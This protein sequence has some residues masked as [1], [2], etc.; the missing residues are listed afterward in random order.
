MVGRPASTSMDQI[1]RD[2]ACLPEDIPILMQKWER[3]V[4][5]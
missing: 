5:W 3:W 1:Y 2:S 4:A